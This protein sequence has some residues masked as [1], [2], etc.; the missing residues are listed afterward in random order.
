MPYCI[1]CNAQ[2]FA[3]FPEGTPQEAIDA[4][5]AASRVKGVT[6]IATCST[7]QAE[8]LQKTGWNYQAIKM[9]VSRLKRRTKC[10]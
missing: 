4:Y 1:Y 6:I 7:G 8:E 3:P 2:C 9:A 10:M 5:N